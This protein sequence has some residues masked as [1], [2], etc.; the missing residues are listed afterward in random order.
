MKPIEYKGGITREQFLYY[1]T[2]IVARL[3][4]QGLSQNEITDI[5][6]RD[7]LFQMPTEKS[8]RSIASGLYKRVTCCDNTN[9]IDLIA[10]GTMD[11]SKQASLYLFM[12]YNRL[13][14][15]FMVDLIGEKFRLKDYSFDKGD[16][17]LFISNIQRA[18]SDVEAWSDTTIVKVKGVLIKCLADTGY[19]N[20]IKDKELN[21][22]Y[23]CDEV[24]D[25]I[26]QNNDEE[27]LKAF[28]YFE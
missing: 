20:S 18:D 21:P 23:L 11:V 26:R 19:L 10:N 12:L 25:C 1:E 15:E 2:K 16:L 27:V 5:I 14:W 13:V 8:I 4:L 9:L 17:N 6:I 24:L 3:V 22:V 28:N 7:N